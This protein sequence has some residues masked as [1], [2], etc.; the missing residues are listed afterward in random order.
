M[1]TVVMFRAGGNRKTGIF[2][3]QRSQPLSACG[4]K[5]KKNKT[6]IQHPLSYWAKNAPLSTNQNMIWQHMVFVLGVT[7]T[8]ESESNSEFCNV[9]DFNQLF[10]SGYPPEPQTVSAPKPTKHKPKISKHE[11]QRKNDIEM[12]QRQKVKSLLVHVLITG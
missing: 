7:A 4:Q 12:C 5:E 3:R 2:D 11:S 1:N 10:S 6:K 9:R 8:K